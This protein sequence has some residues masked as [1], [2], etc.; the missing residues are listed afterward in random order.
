MKK[1]S[2]YWYAAGAFVSLNMFSGLANAGLPSVSENSNANKGDYIAMGSSATKSLIAY[3]VQAV[4]AFMLIG[5]AWMG[6]S[7][8]MDVHNGKKTW[9]DVGKS[10]VAGVGLL[11]IGFILLTQAS[12]M[13]D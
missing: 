11:F 13:V 7:T 6:V 10:I 2:D 9:T 5:V 3:T 1:I 4:G 8:L 12:S